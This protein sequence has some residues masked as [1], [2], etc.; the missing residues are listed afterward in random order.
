M[1]SEELATS[2]GPTTVEKLRGLPWGI[3]WSV[4]NSVFATYTFFGSIFV[5]FL[6]Q[7]GLDKAQIGSL[8]S[9]LPF[10]GIVAVFIA[11]PVAR[12]GHKRVF[13]ISFTTRTALALL[14][15]LV[16]WIQ[17]EF[18]AQ[19]TLA[20]IV[21]AVGAFGLARAVGF[22]AYYPWSQEQIPD[23]MRGKV[24]AIRSILAN[25]TSMLAVLAAGWI[26]GPDP[27]LS[28]FMVLISI[29][30]AAGMFS[31]WA[32]GKLPGGAP[33]KDA[34]AEESATRGMVTAARDRSFVRY[35]LGIGLVTLATMPLTSFVPLFMIEEVGLSSDQAVWLETAVLIG[36]VGSGYLWGWLADRYGSKPVMVLGTYLLPLAPLAWLL[37][38]RGVAMSLYL[39]MAIAVVQGLVNTGWNLGS[40]RLLFV[41]I[42]PSERSSPYMALY[43]AWAGIA[44][45]V[46]TVLGGWLVDLTAD[47]SGQWWIVHFDPYT[48]LFLVGIVLPL[49]GILLF[50]GV[51][52]DSEFTTR[53]FA[54][55]FVRGN[56]LF[57]LG[58]L[59]RYRRARDE[60]AAIEGTERLGSTR[61]PLTVEELIEALHD[62]RFYV[63][64]EAVV[65]MAR[66]GEDPQLIDALIEVLE[67][68]EP[69]LSTMAAW[70]LGR[71]DDERALE[72]LRRGMEAR[73]R[74]VQAHCIRSLG[75]LGDRTMLPVMLERLETE[76]DVGLQMALASAMGK[77]GANGAI[78]RLLVLLR[79]SKTQD[80][81]SEFALAIARLVG[82]EHHFIQ[83]QRRAESEPG[84]A[85]SQEATALKTRLARGHQVEREVVDSLDAA[86]EVLAREDLDRGLV[87][88]AEALRLAAGEDLALP[89][90]QVVRECAAQMERLGPHRLEYVVLALQAA[91]CA[92]PDDGGLF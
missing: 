65:A 58:S 88:L 21:V 18:G 72:A 48:L 22:T 19:A 41:G 17:T 63:R 53:Q 92:I 15:L 91:E 73:Y 37:M 85:F 78:D 66:H 29:G 77:L 13:L 76:Q 64:F 39:A 45:G 31:V 70:A 28:P 62:P 61:S 35:L 2:Q 8:L 40:G 79:E 33:V 49:F 24:S 56:P 84:T 16:P 68:N 67:G 5:L 25:L 1:S 23:G 14:L 7:V 83:L 69:S 50:R 55:M 80:A 4:T 43:Y 52:A 20:L 75:S 10:F 38:P 86:A 57:A 34:H 46:G 26:L 3:A 89:C 74:S 71:L 87:L 90:R 11:A 54:G 44:G 47:V 51:A 82:E 60:R 6:N 42:V 59:V 12:A 9:L 30:V 81:R 27:D 36:A 32:A